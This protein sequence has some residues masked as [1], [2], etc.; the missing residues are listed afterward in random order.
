MQKFSIAFLAAMSLASFG[1]KKKGGA[2][3]MMAQSDKWKEAM[4]ACK[5]KTCVDK[6][7]ADEK[8]AEMEMTKGM[9]EEDMKKRADGMSAEDKKKLEDNEAA[10]QKCATAASGGGSAAAAGDKPAGDKP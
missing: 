5:D 6:T 7:M 2:G 10:E 1:C 3:D 8:K 9:S 4:C